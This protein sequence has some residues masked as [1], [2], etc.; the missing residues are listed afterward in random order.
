MTPGRDD[1]KTLDV[2]PRLRGS[3]APVAGKCASPLA[4]CPDRFCTQDPLV[5]KTRCKFHG[6]RSLSGIAHPK[7][8]HGRYS[9]STQKVRELNRHYL[10]HRH[11][12]EYLHSVDEIALNQARISQ[13]LERLPTGEAGK[14]WKTMGRL[15]DALVDRL[16]E[17][18]GAMAKRN[19]EAAGAA[20]RSLR[21]LA[22]QMRETTT[23]GRNESDGWD[24]INA[25]QFLHTKL[26]TAETKR[27]QVDEK[28]MP[29]MDVFVMV[30][31]IVNVF[32]EVVTDREQRRKFSDRVHAL[33]APTPAPLATIDTVVVDEA[34]A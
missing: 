32:A 9:K 25:Q 24:A 13:L 11:D 14:A 21:P 29:A 34:T 28:S 6:G 20:I 15:I 30:A 17:F 10:T 4:G 7:F 2:R 26:V 5:G 19:S 31:S 12:P 22:G 3:A 16:D 33:I 27:R 8:K 18:D 1:A 23:A